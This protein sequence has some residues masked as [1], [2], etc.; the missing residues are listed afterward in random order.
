MPIN[1]LLRAE[2]HCHLICLVEGDMNL[3][4]R[5]LML[6]GLGMALGGCAP[7]ARQAQ[8]RPPLEWPN[9]EPR[10]RPETVETRPPRPAHVPRPVPRRPASLPEIGRGEWAR[11]GPI[12]RRMQRMGGVNRVTIHHEGWTPVHFSDRQSTARRLESIRKSHLKRMGAGDIGYHYVIDRAGRIWQG[13]PLR[14][15]GAHVKNSNEHNVGIM[16]LGNFNRQ[17]P[18]AAQYASLQRKIKELMRRYNLSAGAIHTHQELGPTTCP[19]H[20]LQSHM[21]RLRRRGLA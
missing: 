18:T 9:I 13:R 19:G 1:R 11:V 15:Q 5:D 7:T 3:T 21:E 12:G 14:Y 20:V 2:A 8:N 16:V 10:P 6:A 17:E 4:R